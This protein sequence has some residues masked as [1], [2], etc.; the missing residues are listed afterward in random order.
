[1]TEEW[2]LDSILGFN[3]LFLKLML[4]FILNQTKEQNPLVNF[5]KTLEISSKFWVFF[6]KEA[7]IF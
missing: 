2:F 1:M 4:G 7:T 3:W 5:T 6:L